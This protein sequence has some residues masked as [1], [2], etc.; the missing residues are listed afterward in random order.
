MDLLGAFF[1]SSVV[2]VCLKKGMESSEHTN[3]QLLIKQTLKASCIGAVLLGAI[4]IGFG[5]VSSLMVQPL[6]IVQ[7]TSLIGNLSQQILGPYA[8]VVA[9][10]LA[11]ALACLTTAIAFGIVIAEFIHH[12]VSSNKIGY[13]PP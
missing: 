10:F 5:F 4:Y 11:V 12:E 6:L 1:F 13:L 9:V 8:G 3:Y 2:L 7:P